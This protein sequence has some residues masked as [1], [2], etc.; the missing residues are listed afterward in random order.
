M[1]EHA[2]PLANP[3]LEVSSFDSDAT[4]PMVMCA[5]PNGDEAVRFALPVAYMELVREFDGVRTIDEAIDAFLQRG[6]GTFERDWLRRLVEKSLIPKGILI[7][8]DQDPARAGVSSQP[9]RA[10]LFIKLPI[11]PPHVVEPIA[12]RLGFMFKTPAMVLGLILAVLSHAYVYGVLLTE[13]RVDFNQLDAAG[14]LAVMLLS[15]LGTLCHEFGHASAAAYYGCRRMTIGWG[16]YIIYTVLW[17]NVS[18]AWKLPRRQRAVVDIGGV[19][20]ES[21]FLLLTL[22]LYLKTGE[23]VFLLAFVIIDLSIVTTFNP[24]LRMDGYWLMSDFFG[25]V[26]LRKQQMLWL[27]HIGG[28]LFG[29]QEPGP[30]IDLSRKAQWALGIYTALGSLFL[31]YILKVIFQFVVLSIAKEYPALLRD[32]VQAAGGGAPLLELLKTF[33]E[34]FWRTLMLAGA[35]VTLWSLAR[36]AVNLLGKLRAFRAQVLR[37]GA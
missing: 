25:I 28:K 31:V 13:Q 9:K 23:L 30:K 29:A 12:R 15:T 6:A 4:K 35:A 22:A 26:N 36:S 18:E 19:Y 27:Q 33:L 8:P 7:H 14:I 21:F 16:V 32:F 11:I 20:F 24:F 37:S 5:V 10:F 17:T 1:T 3:L 2:R 34:V